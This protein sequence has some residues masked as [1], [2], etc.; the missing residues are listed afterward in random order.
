ME[1]RLPGRLGR[2]WSANPSELTEDRTWDLVR[3]ESCATKVASEKLLLTVAA[4][5]ISGWSFLRII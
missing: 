5:A 4:P 3:E 2:G 1:V